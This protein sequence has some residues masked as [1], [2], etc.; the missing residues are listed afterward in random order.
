M[1]AGDIDW[2]IVLIFASLLTLTGLAAN[3]S[4]TG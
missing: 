1:L 3:A 2:I 4:K